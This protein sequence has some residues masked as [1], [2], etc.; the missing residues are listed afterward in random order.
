MTAIVVAVPITLQVPTPMLALASSSAHDAS[1]TS[2]MRRDSQTGQMSST[3]NLSLSWY[4]DTGRCPAARISAGMFALTA[5]IIWAGMVL[6]QPPSSTTPSRGAA[7][8]ISSTSIDNRLRST[9]LVGREK[10]SEIEIVGNSRGRP[11]A[12]VMPAFTCRASPESPWLQGLSS[13]A[14]DAI[15]ITGER[16]TSSALC[17]AP[18]RNARC[19]RPSWPS[20]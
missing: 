14:V 1:S 7:L 3:V 13:L 5:P 9:M 10:G 6:S 12:A 2:P 20:C 8:I 11:P 16:R 18:R 15:P 4:L 17:P 19:S